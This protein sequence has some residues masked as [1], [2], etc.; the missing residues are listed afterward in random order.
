MTYIKLLLFPE[1]E[2]SKAGTIRNV[3][4]KDTLHQRVN[5]NGYWVVSIPIDGKRKQLSVHRLLATAFIPNPENKPQINHKDGNPSNNEITNLEWCTPSENTQHAYATGLAKGR[6]GE[7]HHNCKLT[8]S[9]VLEIRRL[10][11][12]ERL[13]AKE[14]AVKFSITYATVRLIV[15]NLIWTHVAHN[16]KDQICNNIHRRGGHNSLERIQSKL[17]FAKP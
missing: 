1:F 2:I 5:N 6:K 13:I 15:S 16:Y 4:T 8:E 10:Y 11:Y 3:I 9:D 7:R 12:V 17:L 14:I